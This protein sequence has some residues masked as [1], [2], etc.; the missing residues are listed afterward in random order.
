[1]QHTNQSA[2]D[3][4]VPAKGCLESAKMIYY[5]PHRQDSRVELTFLPIH[6]LLGFSA[7]LFL[8]AWL[9]K[10]GLDKDA[11]RKKPFGHD[12]QR[13]SDEAENRGL[14]IDP[15]L[16]SLI[17]ALSG[18]HGDYTFRYMEPNTVYNNTDL[19]AALALLDGLD[20]LVD[21]GIGASAD[22]GLLPGH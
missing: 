8:K 14:P 2:V 9:S 21:T 3:F 1:M 15:A 7:E 22:H 13:L 6:L 19:P 5:S 18:P 10:A 4:Y 12:L 11:L 20:T 17:K 16:G